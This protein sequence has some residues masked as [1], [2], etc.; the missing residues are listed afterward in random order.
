MNKTLLIILGLALAV[1]VALFALRSLQP[2]PAPI[3]PPAIV[4]PTPVETV[5]SEV[6]PVETTPS[7]TVPAE[8]LP[9]ETLPVETVPAE[10]VPAETVAPATA[11]GDT[12][13]VVNGTPITQ[14]QLDNGVESI[15]AQYESIYSQMGQDFNSLLAGAQGFAL[16]Q[17]VKAQALERLTFTVI[18]DAEV[19][20]RGLSV[21]D[22]ELNAEFDTQYANFLQTQNLTEESLSSLLAAQGMTLDQFKQGGRDS[23]KSQLLMMK[24]QTAVAGPVDLTEDEI[25]AYWDKNKANYETSEQ[26][27]ASHILVKTEDEAKAVLAEIEAGGDFAT[28]AKE[29]STDTGTASKGGDLGWFGAGTMVKEFEDAAFALQV[30]Q[31]SG[32]V[33]TQ[34]GYHIILLTDRKPATKPELADV[35]DKVVADAKQ[36]IVSERANTWYDEIMAAADVTVTDPLLNAARLQRINIDLGLQAYESLWAAGTIAE[37]YLPY[38]VGTLYENKIQTLTRS[39]T[40]LEAATPPDADKIADVTQQIADAKAKALAAYRDALAR[41]GGDADIQARI[42]ALT[43]PPVTQTPSDT[44]SP[45]ESTPTESAPTESA[46]TESAPAAP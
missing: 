12:I 10:T 18:A 22:D 27:R 31:H 26:L 19:K 4:R 20:T 16:T 23:I 14:A 2:T 3:S 21:S 37:P 42:D 11:A 36:E 44:V 46:P 30:G 28:L 32:I 17:G 38:V 29:K 24:L 45:T 43:A 41:S 1:G 13:A 8:T 39:K 40:D 34:Y 9:V 7:A 25:Q 33:Q 5:P 6:T 35:R 15:L